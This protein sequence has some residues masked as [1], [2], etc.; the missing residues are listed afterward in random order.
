MASTSTY[1]LA[2]RWLQQWT[3]SLHTM[4]NAL[5]GRDIAMPSLVLSE[6]SMQHIET[7]L[8]QQQLPPITLVEPALHALV[9]HHTQH[10]PSTHQNEITQSLFSVLRDVTLGHLKPITARSHPAIHQEIEQM[11]GKAGWLLGVSIPTPI[12]FQ[13][14]STAHADPYL[15]YIAIPTDAT[16]PAAFARAHETAH[17]VR[18]NHPSLNARFTT[19]CERKHEEHHADVLGLQLLAATHRAA[20]PF[21]TILHDIAERPSHYLTPSQLQ[22]I[23]QIVQQDRYPSLGYDH[24]CNLTAIQSHPTPEAAQKASATRPR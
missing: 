14:D 2:S 6:S 11:L 16:A 13:T 21:S 24:A 12:I 10:A 9:H 18:F 4:A 8:L 3:Q 15:R 23:A 7:Q 5:T 19:P 1:P 17:Y 22:R 20:K